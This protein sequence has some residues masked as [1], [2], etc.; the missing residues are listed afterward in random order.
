[1]RRADVGIR[2]G[3]GWVGDSCGSSDT[4]DKRTS[5]QIIPVADSPAAQAALDKGV[6]FYR[7][8]TLES[9]RR[10]IIKFAEA[11]QLSRLAKD[12]NT[13]AAAMAWT[14]QVYSDLGEKQKALDLYNQ[15]LPL[16]RA[17]EDRARE[18][19]TLSNIGRVYSDLGEIQKALEFYNQA[20]SLTR[21]VADRTQEAKIL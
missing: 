10:A 7:Q 20:L 4:K 16:I 15:S 13:E 11:A 12:K 3:V 18:A 19:A 8:K 21:A 14:G 1:M 6:K 17:V 9:F 2:K 5:Q